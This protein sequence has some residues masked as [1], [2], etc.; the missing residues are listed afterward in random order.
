MVRRKMKEE[1]GQ[2]S[3]KEKIWNGS[4]VA[5]LIAAV[6]VFGVM[7]QMEKNMLTKYERGTIYIASKEIPEGL[8]LTQNN[9]Q[10]YFKESLLDS[11]CIPTTAVSSP[12]QITNL[13]AA[14]KIDE[15][16]LLTMGMFEPLDEIT[17]AMK[18]PVVAGLKADDLYQ[19]VGGILRAGD[20]V[21]IYSVREEGGTELVWEN[22]YVQGVFDQAGAVISNAD[23][24]TAVQRIN[25]YLDKID[26]ER[27]YSELAVGSLRVVKVC[28]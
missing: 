6:A 28:D 13:V 24:I 25:V 11:N 10:E 18:E 27:F 26:V 21:H 2:G 15:G 5:A 17:A 23:T 8:M 3:I 20:R 12:E 19:M 7:L 4:I 14:G 1:K 16:T 9:Y 22:I